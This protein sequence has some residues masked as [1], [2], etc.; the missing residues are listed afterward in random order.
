MIRRIAIWIAVITLATAWNRVSAQVLLT[1]NDSNPSAVTFTATGANSAVN[2]SGNTANDGVDLL[3][4]FVIDES[5]MLIGVFSGGTLVGGSMG[6]QYAYNYTWSDSYSTSGS[7]FPDLELYYYNDASPS[8]NATEDFSTTA[9]AFTGSWTA[10]LASLGVS[11]SA[12]PAAGTEGNI[13]SGFSG[14]PGVVIGQWQ[15]QSV[16]EPA[17]TGLLAL[18]GLLAG[19]GIRRRR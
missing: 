10:D 5:N 18:A 17:T 14:N 4:F 13:L 9:P 1:I 19:F 3:S 16:P 2:Y 7:T 8:S 11:A 12:L 6:S 15:V